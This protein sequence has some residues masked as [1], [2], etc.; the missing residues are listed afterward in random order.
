[1]RFEVC[2][3]TRGIPGTYDLI[4]SFD[5]VHDMPR[6]RPALQE[7]RLA[8]KPGGTYFVLEFNFFGDLQQN[9]DHPMGI[10]AFGYSASTNY[11]MTQALAVGGEGTGT[12]MGEEKMREMAREAGFS[13]VRRLDFPANPF[14]IFYEIRV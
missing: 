13:H 6:P 2:D 10:G 12:Y 7:I 8:L 11:R 14:N 3:V 5:V 1:V 9:L 4:T